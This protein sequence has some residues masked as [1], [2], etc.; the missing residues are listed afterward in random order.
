MTIPMNNWCETCSEACHDHPTICS[1]CG[2]TLTAPPPTSNDAS[3]NI[4]ANHVLDTDAL[5]GILNDMRQASSELNDVLEGLRGQVRT[6]DA[7]TRNIL[8]HEQDQ[9]VPPELLSLEHV[10]TGRPTSQKALAQIPRIVLTDKSTLFRQ[11]TL[12]IMDTATGADSTT[13]PVMLRI[14]ALVGE[15]GPVGE[16]HY[17]G[18]TLIV[19]S[20]LTGKGGLSEQTMQE[21][22][23]A[24]TTT[25]TT[26]DANADGSPAGCKVILYLQRGDGLTFV[27]KALLA[28][29]AGASAVV[30][31]NNTSF[32]WPYIMKD[33]KQES[34]TH[35]LSIPVVMVKEEDGKKI[36]KHP[37]EQEGTVATKT[38]CCNLH[39][40]A[41]SHDCVV[42]CEGL[43]NNETVIQLPGCAH[44]F[45]EE[46]AMAWLKTHN[47]CPY[48]RRELPTD[49]EEYERERRRQQR[50]HAGSDGAS[51]AT[52]DSA[53]NE[54]YG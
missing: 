47:T 52:S 21:I 45:H 16:H 22:L 11:A 15:F 39:I 12:Q 28:Q 42:C 27:Q 5:H 19:A 43:Q 26:D 35:G 53:W 36:I 4:T 3:H 23:E 2:D 25:T 24:T 32:P 34:E 1:V 29:K 49:D 8:Q 6:L 33:S 9:A 48:C 50:T 14:S 40:T 44:I 37:K 17:Q 20:P 31:G 51:A 41:Q 54:Y 46:C 30:I 38:L 13:V 10:H 18:S 7:M